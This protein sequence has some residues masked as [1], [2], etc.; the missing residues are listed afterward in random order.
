MGIWIYELG[1][2]MRV[3]KNHFRD[4]ILSLFLIYKIEYLVLN[5][6]QIKTPNLFPCWEFLF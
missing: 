3:I 1:L 2:K 4:E 6:K 5:K